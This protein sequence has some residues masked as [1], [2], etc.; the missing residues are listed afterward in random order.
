MS[1]VGMNGVLR[2]K[3]KV[4][5]MIF[6]IKLSYLSIL[7][8]MKVLFWLLIFLFCDLFI[9]IRWSIKCRVLIFFLVIVCF[10]WS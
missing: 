4:F 3:L 9:L 1:S 8:L 7:R 5:I 6:V 2:V 10:D